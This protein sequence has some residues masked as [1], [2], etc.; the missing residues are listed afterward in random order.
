MRGKSNNHQIEH[1][2]MPVSTQLCSIYQANSLL[3]I[4]NTLLVEI[5]NYLERMC[6]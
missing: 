2:L 3:T 4:W 5:I 1:W 6:Q